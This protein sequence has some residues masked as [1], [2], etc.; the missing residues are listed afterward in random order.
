MT[1]APNLA[2]RAAAGAGGPGRAA[3]VAVALAVLV[4]GATAPRA[5]RADSLVATRTL[6]AQTVL[7]AA[8]MT[9]VEAAIPDALADPALAVGLEARVTLYAGRAIRAADVGP[10]ALVDRNQVVSLIYLAGGLGIVTEGRALAR[11]GA[12]D[13]VRVMNLSSRS[14]VTGR[15]APDGTVLVGN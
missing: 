10:P 14:T 3:T 6:R 11:A 2:R 7:T 13:A 4:L 5:L 9:L 15:V 12:G 1:R 8:D